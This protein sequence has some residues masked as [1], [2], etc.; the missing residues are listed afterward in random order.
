[1]AL[2]KTKIWAHLNADEKMALTLATGNGKSTWEAGTIMGKSHY[3]FLEIFYR[4]THFLKLFTQH[5]Q[6]HRD[7]FS[8]DLS[9][10]PIIKSYLDLVMRL[11]YKPSDAIKKLNHPI[12]NVTRHRT[13]MFEKELEK[14]RVSKIASEQLFY[15]L[16][17]E[18]D[19]WNNHRILP[20]ELQEPHAFKRRNK[21]SLRAVMKGWMNMKYN[22]P[23]LL[24]EL[25]SLQVE[26]KKKQKR[27]YIGI[28]TDGRSYQF[29][30][31][32]VK[33]N[34]VTKPILKQHKIF[35]FDTPKK[36]HN[37]MV[38]VTDYF[39]KHE[40]KS[41]EGLI[42]WPIIRTDVQ[43]ALNHNEIMGIT[44]H[45]DIILKNPYTNGASDREIL[46]K[47]GIDI[48]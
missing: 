28:I 33:Y 16:V 48:N 10:S 3:K 13:L 27:A 12:F 18:F 25:L 42:F 41:A 22:N 20:K 32:K 4:G 7:F 45:R 31:I 8:E 21:N 17:M 37:L 40:H 19:R 46:I 44:P 47:K 38:I 2:A 11:R 23:M 24:K 9:I 6:L 39:A 1:M 29:E 43:M 36:A 26:D 34:K 30:V 35:A 14:W 5:Y 15:H